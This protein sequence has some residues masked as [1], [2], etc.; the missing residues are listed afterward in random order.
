MILIFLWSGFIILV[1]YSEEFGQYQYLFSGILMF[2][3]TYFLNQIKCLSISL[4]TVLLLVNIPV[5]ILWY[6]A[7]VYNDFLAINP[8]SHEFFII[9]FF[10]YAYSVFYFILNERRKLRQ[11]LVFTNYKNDV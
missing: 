1:S 9:L 11:F 2:W 3:A 5:S 8:I 4:R 10:I 7:F 6:V